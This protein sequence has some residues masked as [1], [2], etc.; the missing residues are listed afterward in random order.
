LI[1]GAVWDVPPTDIAGQSREALTH[2]WVSASDNVGAF[3]AAADSWFGAAPNGLSEIFLPPLDTQV[4]VTM[5]TECGGLG[6]ENPT[7]QTVY[8]PEILAAAAQPGFGT[9]LPW[10]CY[11]KEN[12]LPTTSLPRADDIPA[13]FLLGELDGLVNDAVER[14]SFQTLCS[15]GMKLVYLECA[16]ATHTAPLV[17][18]FDQTLDFLEDRL[19][20]KPLPTDTCVVKPAEKCTS[21]P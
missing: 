14:A 4:P 9:F 11:M 17:Y 19:D 13:L 15:Q 8:T 21:Q 7:L 10:A 18:A 1:R 20:G 5:M 12:S 2:D 16:G 6:F 3:L